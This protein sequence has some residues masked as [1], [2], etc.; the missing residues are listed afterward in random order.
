ME[1][2]AEYPKLRDNFRADNYIFKDGQKYVVVSDVL[3]QG[4]DSKK[5]L[6]LPGKLWQVA[7]LM[8]G[9]VDVD[10]LREYA[11]HIFWT[12]IKREVIESV[13]SQLD[14]YFLLDNNRYREKLRQCKEDLG[15]REYRPII[16]DPRCFTSECGELTEELGRTFLSSHG[17][18]NLPDNVSHPPKQQL[19]GLV[20]P[21]GS[22]GVSG[23]CAAHAYREISLADPFDLF[24]II[25][26]NHIYANNSIESLHKDVKTPLGD[27]QVDREFGNA[28]MDKLPD[29]V[30]QGGVANYLEHS[31]DMQLPMLRYVLNKCGREAKIYPFILANRPK[32]ASI[33]DALDFRK[34]VSNVAAALREVVKEQGKNVCII[35]SG[36][37]THSGPYYGT[38][39]ITEA[40]TAKIKKFD[41]SNLDLIVQMQKDAFYKHAIESTY[42]CVTPIYF[43]LSVLEPG[44]KGKLLKYYSSWDI[45]GI[46][47][48]INT[49]AALGFYAD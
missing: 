39:K 14:E 12:D 49:F 41:Q 31:I 20:V 29:R 7:V 30:R 11:M 8:N 25:G 4:R 19:L 5:K 15:R 44:C 17:P 13:I 43:L 3:I 9:A 21:H 37:F 22:Y 47:E 42:C 24:V 16:D 33:T 27:L 23:P 48:N 28:L 10:T 46:S 32:F 6:V 36:D 34:V 26:Y 2:Y 38:A 35:A 18:G 1:K 45:L 40:D